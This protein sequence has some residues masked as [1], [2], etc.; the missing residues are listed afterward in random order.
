MQLKTVF[1]LIYRLGE[2]SLSVLTNRS[3]EM[4]IKATVAIVL[5]NLSLLTD[6]FYLN[7]LISFQQTLLSFIAKISK[8]QSL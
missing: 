6:P 5:Q 7:L 4:S 1:A 8:N 2:F 3:N